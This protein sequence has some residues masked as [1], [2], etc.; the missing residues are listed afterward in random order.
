MKL[1][2]LLCVAGLSLTGCLDEPTTGGGYL[3]GMRPAKPSI[4]NPTNSDLPAYPDIFEGMSSRSAFTMPDLNADNVFV[5]T[6]TPPVPMPEVCENCQVT[7]AHVV[8]DSYMLEEIRVF[9]D[10]GVPI[11]RIFLDTESG[12]TIHDDCGWTRP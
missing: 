4:D 11:C 3:A 8:D 5:E 9:S 7:A 2:A 10:G 12:T 6:M 1:S